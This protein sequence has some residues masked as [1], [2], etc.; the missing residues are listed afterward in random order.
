M[1]NHGQPC[2][3]AWLQFE[4]FCVK[5]LQSHGWSELGIGPPS[6]FFRSSQTLDFSKGVLNFW[7]ESDDWSCR[8]S[9][10]LAEIIAKSSIIKFQRTAQADRDIVRS[11]DFFAQ[12]KV[13][14]VLEHFWKNN[15]KAMTSFVVVGVVSW[16][17][18]KN[19]RKTEPVQSLLSGGWSERDIGA[20][21]K[22]FSSRQTLDFS[23]GVLNIWC[24]SDV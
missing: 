11:A 17:K 22:N 16:T 9:A 1:I 4:L 10:W 18:M 6:N 23:E 13:Y 15:G 12:T 8:T 5:L 14:E 24:E 2:Y 19:L 20:P 7:C 3:R 21:T